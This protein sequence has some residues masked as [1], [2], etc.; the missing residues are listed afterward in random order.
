[1]KSNHPSEISMEKNIRELLKDTIYAHPD[2][3]KKAVKATTPK[4]VKK[5]KGR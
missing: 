2:D 3:I 4:E 5:T 1:M